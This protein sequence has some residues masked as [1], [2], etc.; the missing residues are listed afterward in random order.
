[1]RTS[2]RQF[3]PVTW[4]IIATVVLVLFFNGCGQEEIQ[5]LRSENEALKSK[6][7]SLEQE[8]AKLKETADYHYQ[9]GIAFLSSEKYE[10]AKSEFQTIVE[11]YPTSP[12]VPSAKQQ[13]TKANDV[14]AEIEAQ[15]RAEERR[16]QEEERQPWR[17]KARLLHEKIIK[18]AMWDIGRGTST[19]VIDVITQEI[20]QQS[21]SYEGSYGMFI[22]Y[23]W[24]VS[25]GSE[26]SSED[27][28]KAPFYI[29]LRRNLR[30]GDYDGKACEYYS[31][32]KKIDV[33][34]G[35]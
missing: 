11:K 17:A 33:Y 9:Q 21:N 4:S 31:Y 5:K 8:N 1:M 22:Y 18:Q 34:K 24:G 10:E 16:K 35:F 32:G 20:G 3:I 25:L 26:A 28:K 2:Q 27:L 23:V 7:V 13:L 29:I 15:R 19:S 6:M 14:L 12:M 30:C